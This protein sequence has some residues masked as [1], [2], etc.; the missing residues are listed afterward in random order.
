MIEMFEGHRKPVFSGKK[1][2][3]FSRAPRAMIPNRGDL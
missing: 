3:L 1:P 2:N